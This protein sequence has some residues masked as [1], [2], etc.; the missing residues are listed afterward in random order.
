MMLLL[1]FSNA[2]PDGILA[3]TVKTREFSLSLSV[4]DTAM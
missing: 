4:N 2:A 3:T 1:S